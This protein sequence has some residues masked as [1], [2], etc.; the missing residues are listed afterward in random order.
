MLGRA[1]VYS[2]RLA[3]NVPLLFKYRDAT[4]VRKVV[5][6][7]NLIVAARALQRPELAGSAVVECGTWKGGMAAA[8]MEI[9]GTHRRYCFF[10][11]FEGLP[12]AEPIDGKAALEYQSAKNSPFYYNNCAATIE[13]FKATIARTAVPIE[14]VEIY[15]G[16]FEQTFPGFNPPPVAVLRLDAD[17][18]SSTMACLTKFWDSVMPGGLVIIDDYG[19]WDGCTKAVHDF[20]S[21]RK[22]PEPIRHTTFGVAFIEKRSRA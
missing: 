17:W 5:F 4:M 2:W 20:L 15:K 16:L 14:K 8:L 21:M 3:R 10:D 13:E 18:Y 1:I 9:G 7:E 12:P 22:A 11:S 19:N 6:L